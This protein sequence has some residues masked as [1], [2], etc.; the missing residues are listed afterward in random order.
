MNLNNPLRQIFDIS[1]ADTQTKLQKK[2]VR[3][4]FDTLYSKFPKSRSS[5]SISFETATSL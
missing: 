2:S 4:S 5:E 1:I 3:K